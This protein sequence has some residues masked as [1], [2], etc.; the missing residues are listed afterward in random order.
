MIVHDRFD[1]FPIGLMWKIKQDVLS[2][3]ETAVWLKNKILQELR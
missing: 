1:F 2:M 3:M